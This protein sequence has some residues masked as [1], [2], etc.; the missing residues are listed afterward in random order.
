MAFGSRC[1]AC[2]EGNL[3]KGFLKFQEECEACGTDFRD[4]DA[5]DG[6]AFFAMFAVLIVIIPMAIAF[7]MVTGVPMWLEL[8]IWGPVIIGLCLFLLRK[9]RGVM[10]NTAWRRNAREVPAKDM[11][12]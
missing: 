11:K 3:F 5:G 7:Q 8:L 12:Q 9:L 2:G 10:F 1:P 4:E 6:P